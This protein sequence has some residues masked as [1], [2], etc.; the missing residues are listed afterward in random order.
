MAKKLGKIT[1]PEAESFKGKRKLYLVPLIFSREKAPEEYV[2]KF[3][4]YWKQVGEHIAGLE[5]KAG[6]VGHVYY[7][8]DN[9]GGDGGLEIMEKLNPPSFQIVKAKCQGGAVLEPTEDKELVEENMDWERIL[10]MGFIS[11]KV[12]KAVSE[13]Y[14]S[15]LKKRFE[16]IARRIDETLKSGGAGMLFMRE[17]HGIQFPQD[18]EVFS[19]APPALDEIHRW[20]RDSLAVK[21]RGEPQRESPDS[22][23]CCCG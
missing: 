10:L 7:E 5:L 23:G 17:G 13:F 9:F 21:E 11:Q 18:I 1:K 12:S 6:K 15:T 20:Q 19:V 2:A 16:H 22:E 3:N 14:V 8:L 4:L